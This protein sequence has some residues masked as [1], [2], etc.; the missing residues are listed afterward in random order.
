MSRPQPLLR[1]PVGVVIERRKAASSWANFVWRPVAAFSGTPDTRPWTVLDQNP[2]ATTFYAGSAEVGLF[3]SGTP[4]YRENLASN[5]PSLWVVLRPTAVDPP[6]EVL[7]VTAD[8]AEGEAFTQA[9]DD[10][11]EAVAMPESIR[12]AIEFF[13]KEHHVD[14]TFVKRKRDQADPEALARRAPKSKSGGDE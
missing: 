8:P 14:S 6:F 1:M 9:G 2:E 4:F 7:A 12:E 3:A 5:Q 10:L 13:V 11:V